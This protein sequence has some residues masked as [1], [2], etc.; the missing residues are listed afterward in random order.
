MT[1]S[2]VWGRNKKIRTNKKIRY[3]CDIPMWIKDILTILSSHVCSDNFA[4]H[5]EWFLGGFHEQT[6]R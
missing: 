5:S 3:V 2:L 4:K 6:S 1:L